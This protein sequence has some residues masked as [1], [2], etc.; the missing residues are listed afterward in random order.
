MLNFACLYVQRI[1]SKTILLFLAYD[2]SLET[3]NK[4]KSALAMLF[5]DFFSKI[6]PLDLRDENQIACL[7]YA[8][9]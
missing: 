2:P 5:Q 7:G 9:W 3:E 1:T 6:D 8:I 4:H